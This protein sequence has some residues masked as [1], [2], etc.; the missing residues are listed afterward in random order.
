M[1]FSIIVARDRNS[2]IGKHNDLPWHLPKDFAYF[3]DTTT[4]TEDPEKQNAI[5]MGLNTWES[6][7]RKPL[8]NRLNVVLSRD[9][10]D[11]EIGMDDEGVLWSNSLEKALDE[12]EGTVEKAFVIGGGSLYAY[13][14]TQPDCE[15]LYI[16]E[17]DGEF[18][19]DIF[20]P[21]VPEDY[22]EVSRSETVAE[23]GVEYDFVVYQRS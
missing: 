7:P 21:E 10:S 9:L 2:G 1:K 8:K 13:A 20:F 17:I 15:T 3:Q 11:D 19:C 4:K 12:I 6:L 22:E 23:K 14:I 5:I 18:D 16:T